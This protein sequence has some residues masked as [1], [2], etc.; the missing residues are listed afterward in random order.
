RK[1]NRRGKKFKC[2]ACSFECDADLNA[3]R[4]IALEGLPAISKSQ[5]L[6]RANRKGFYWHEVVQECIVPEA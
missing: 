1:R 2:K 6:L 4:N 5:R 3:A